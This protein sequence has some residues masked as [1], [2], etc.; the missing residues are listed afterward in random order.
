M[1]VNGKVSTINGYIDIKN[2]NIGDY[3][4][5]RRNRRILITDIKL[6]QITNIIT[7]IK[8]PEIV[9]SDDTVLNTI[10]GKKKIQDLLD[11]TIYFL[12]PNGKIEKEKYIVTELETPVIGYQI[13]LE[14]P[15]SYYVNQ[16]SID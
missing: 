16:Y 13:I 10:Y 5:N 6:S 12:L 15:D 7:F 2:L 1:I 4:L 8:D 14:T 3:V 11:D 9:L